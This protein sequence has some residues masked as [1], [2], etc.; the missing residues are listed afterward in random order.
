[1][2]SNILNT[3][4]LASTSLREKA[5]E[6]MECAYGAVNIENA[7]RSRIKIEKGVLFID[8]KEVKLN[9]FKNIYIT[10][11]GKGSFEAVRVFEE[12]LDKSGVAIKDGVVIDVIGG[13][14]KH[15]RGFIGTH[16]LPSKNNIEATEELI[17]LLEGAGSK[18]LIITFIFGGG[19]AL[20]CRPRDNF[21]YQQLQDLTDKL[22]KLAV[23]IHKINI[24]RKH[25]SLIHGGF[26]AKFAYPAKVVALITSD[27]P[28]NDL[29]VV[30]SG[31]TVFD[32]STVYDAQEAAKSYGINNLDF[33]ETPKDRKYFSGIENIL[34][35][36]NIKAAR[37]MINKA[38][39]LGFKTVLY[40]LQL[41]G[42][43]CLAGQRIINLLDKKTAVIVAG[44]TTVTVKGEGKGGRNQE[45]VL[46]SLPIL[47]K[48]SLVT[49]FASDAKDHSDAAG[50]IAD[51]NTLKRAKEAGI[52]PKAHLDNNDAYNFFEPLG[53]LIFARR[54]S[55]NV[56]DLALFLR[57]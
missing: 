56:S 57:D 5:L 45:F 12:L 29:S 47:P 3:K 10:G 7:L 43:A 53:D 20:A 36:S 48:D 1:M 22:L 54:T 37:A 32:V 38:E 16:P 18:D 42:E 27:V 44:E 50:A 17:K 35:L 25:L 51:S 11:V 13:Q 26:F 4:E 31:L 21:T 49:S 2:S 6:I 24:M 39:D 23:P 34:F 28:G 52:D 15:V 30:A 8:A 19:S 55:A 40:S 9:D 41:E 33:I 14:L 46:G